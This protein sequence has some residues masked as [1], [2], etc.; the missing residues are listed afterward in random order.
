[1]VT[2]LLLS[3]GKDLYQVPIHTIAHMLC[4]CDSSSVL[5]MQSLQWVDFIG[6]GHFLVIIHL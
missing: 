4:F 1:M 2:E 6:L 5:E 3:M